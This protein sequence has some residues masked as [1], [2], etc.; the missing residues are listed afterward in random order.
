MIL[1]CAASNGNNLKLARSIAGVGT[2]MGLE[3]QVLDLT[4]AG[5]PMYTP[6]R[7]KE[8]TPE[9][10]ASIEDLFKAAQGY[11]FCAP[12]YNGSTPPI[13]SNTIAWLSVASDDFR[14]LFN[15]R[16][17]GLATHSGGGG[18]K[19]LMTMRT[20][21]SHLGCNVVGREITTSKGKA[22][23]PTSARS[24]IEQLSRLSG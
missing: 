19:V 3:L 6:D 5:L 1:I 15:G 23:N 14:S 4:T 21:F 2:E 7:E 12:E 17:V 20:Q 22:F 8:G 11:V 18:S 24:V 10:L 9:E 13:L 16:P